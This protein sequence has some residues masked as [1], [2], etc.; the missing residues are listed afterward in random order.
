VGRVP[1]NPLI[2]KTGE[3]AMHYSIVKL[4]MIP[5]M[6]KTREGAI[7]AVKVFVELRKIV[8]T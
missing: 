2:L 6:P 5:L 3:G 4:F 1:R 7:E 8:K